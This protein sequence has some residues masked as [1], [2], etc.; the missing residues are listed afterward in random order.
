MSAR[1]RRPRDR[2]SAWD[3]LLAVPVLVAVLP[4][5][6][7]WPR[8]HD[9]RYE[10]VKIAEFGHAVGAGQLP[11]H[12]AENLYG[13]L[14]STI[15]L[16]YAPVYAAVA[17]VAG[18]L[19]GSVPRGG[20][21]A[22]IGFTIVGAYA[23]YRAAAQMT[24]GH[25]QAA[26]VAAAIFILHPY[27]IG[28]VLLR[29]ATSEFAALC[30]VFLGLW[31]VLALTDRPRGG[32]AL[33][34]GGLGLTVITHNITALVMFVIVAAAGLW[35]HRGRSERSAW[36]WLALGLGLALGMSAFFWL[37]A[38]ALRELVQTDSMITGRFDFR[39]NFPAFGSLFG[40]SRFF[41][42]G[43]LAALI[44]GASVVTAVRWRRERAARP[45][46][47][48]VVMA[49]GL[50]ALMTPLTTAVWAH[51]P[52][53]PYLQ[54]PWRLQ[55]PLAAVTA[56]LAGCLFARRSRGWSSGR[57][58]GAEVAVLALAIANSLPHLLAGQPLTPAEAAWAAEG[59]TPEALSSG[60][61]RA[62]VLD[63]YLP[64]S[65]DPAALAERSARGAPVRT[66]RDA[67]R[68]VNLDMGS[69]IILDVVAESETW[70]T[71]QRWGFPGW[72]ARVAGGLAP[73]RVDSLGRLQVR[74]EA[75]SGTVHLRKRA[76][77]VR[78]AALALS[79][80]ASLLWIGLLRNARRREP[81]RRRSPPDAASE[82]ARRA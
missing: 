47:F 52:L 37:P 38:L 56:L 2:L 39:E 26:R 29:N 10:L 71:L 7:G 28:D 23:V 4:L 48:F 82:P 16:F 78:R 58:H 53:L 66:P 57:R 61:Y 51:T 79:A 65:A 46:R 8:G 67:V 68:A 40:Y 50:V 27:L 34:A 41:G 75:G 32:A 24:G 22:L 13:G 18:A 11:P 72:E 76:P 3:A 9:W 43:W 20:V 74:V 6:R 25:T 80:I 70:L 59:L 12:W 49:L 77:G 35:L 17:T 60:V 45:L 64:A 54:F 42:A 31:G 36:P 62:S 69:R 44:L 55:G 1:P 15:F 73:T 63:E 5:L 33:L 21:L 81:G 14:G 19:T 30:V